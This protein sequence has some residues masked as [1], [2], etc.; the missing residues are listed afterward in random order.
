MSVP[1]LKIGAVLS[2]MAMVTNWMSQTLPSLVGL[3]GTAIA[4]RGGTSERIVSALYPSPEE[5]WQIYSSAQG[6]DGKCICTVVAPAQSVCNRDPRSRQLRQLMEKV[7]A[8][9]NTTRSQTQLSTRAGGARLSDTRQK[10]SAII[11]GG[12]VSRSTVAVVCSG[13]YGIPLLV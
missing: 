8:V 7:T 5:G 3:N 4:S 2:T 11:L 12:K 10:V 9:R 13:L 1:M 6:T